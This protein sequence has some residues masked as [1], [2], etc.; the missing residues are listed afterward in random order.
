MLEPQAYFKGIW[1]GYLP[2]DR[3]R[4]H[5]TGPH[6][7]L[8]IAATASV[9]LAGQ[10]HWGHR[11]PFNNNHW[12]ASG[13]GLSSPLQQHQGDL[14]LGRQVAEML[15]I[16]SLVGGGFLKKAWDRERLMNS[17]ALM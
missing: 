17:A 13:E 14:R 7:D 11:P 10:Q 3:Q 6:K 1:R 2:E 8:E 9:T 15:S 4:T 12:L 16:T 5:K